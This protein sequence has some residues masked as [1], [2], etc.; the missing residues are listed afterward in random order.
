MP[1][2]QGFLD[3]LVRSTTPLFVGAIAGLAAL[4]GWDLNPVQVTGI[5]TPAVSL[6]FAAGAHWLE[7]RYPR[8]KVLL[9]LGIARKSPV[10][11]GPGEGPGVPLAQG[12][13]S[14]CG[15]SEQ[16]VVDPPAH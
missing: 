7:Q 5:V 1:N 16:T 3:F 4:I 6:V 13:I 2:S 8:A 14:L 11:V 10:Y 12:L 15:G 9:G